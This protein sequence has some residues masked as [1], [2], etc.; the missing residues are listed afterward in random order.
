MSTPG[1]A[2]VSCN[3]DHKPQL[4]SSV[5]SKI[6]ANAKLPKLIL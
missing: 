6:D 4:T 3:V 1:H 2:T 5:F